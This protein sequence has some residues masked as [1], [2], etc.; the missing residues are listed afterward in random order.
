MSFINLDVFLLFNYIVGALN[1]I[2]LTLK[3]CKH[4]VIV[5]HIK[6]KHMALVMGK[7]NFLSTTRLIL[8]QKCCLLVIFDKGNLQIWEGDTLRSYHKITLTSTKVGHKV[9][10]K[11][12]KV[13]HCL[14]LDS[15]AAFIGTHSYEIFI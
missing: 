13:V 1:S 11:A 10:L 14:S 12:C 4:D 8:D 3:V 7:S 2:W 9:P 15:Q 5:K 6:L